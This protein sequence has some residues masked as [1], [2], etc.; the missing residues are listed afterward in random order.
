MHYIVSLLKSYA[1]FLWD[2]FNVNLF[3]LLH[4]L[5]LHALRCV[6]QDIKRS[7]FHDRS[8]RSNL[9]WCVLMHDIFECMQMQMRCE[10]YA[11]WYCFMGFLCQFWSFG[12][13]YKCTNPTTNILTLLQ[14]CWQSHYSIK[15]ASAVL[16]FGTE[17]L[18][19]LKTDERWVEALC[20]CA[21]FLD[22]L[23]NKSL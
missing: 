10:S 15:K 8:V 17:N 11:G 1:S 6:A 23:I 21:V 7:W 20:V 3:L 19:L 14:C 5:H 16:G 13:T 9:V 2:Q 4:L 12:C 18:I 22:C